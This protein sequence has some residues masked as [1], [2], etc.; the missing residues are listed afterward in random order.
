MAPKITCLVTLHGT[1]FMQPPQARADGVELVN[2]GYAD[3]LHQ[4]LKQCLE[5]KLSDDPGRT[6]PKPGD[7]GAIYV[8]S[9]WLD[10]QKRASREEELKRLGVWRYDKQHVDTP[11]AP[12]V[13]NDEPVSH[14][15]LVYSKL[16]PMGPAIGATLITFGTGLTSSSHYAGA[17]GLIHMALAEGL[18]M[19]EQ[20]AAPGQEPT[21]SRP[22]INLWSRLV[23]RP[24]QRGQAA[25]AA[26]PGLLS[27]LR[28]FED[29]VACYVSRNED[30]ER[31]RSFVYEALMR[32]AYREDVD[33]I[34]LN[35]HSNG[36]VI[37]FDVLRH[38]LEEVTSKIKAFVTAGSPL[39]KYV[40]CFQW[41]NQIQTRFP[42]EPWYN[43]WDR[44]DPV[45]DPLAPP[46]SWH[47][48]DQIVPSDEQLFSRIDL[49]T[50]TPYWIKVDDREVDNSKNSRGGG[51][52]VH[53]YWDNEV[54][55]VKQLCNIVRAIA[56]NQ[57]VIAE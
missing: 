3:P 56:N 33:T 8:E 43:F 12:L 34:V 41:G 25:P 57:G 38:L 55:F 14:V 28:D 21:S 49:N 35:T 23:K 53:N 32:L 29:D 11:D 40:D 30:R 54:E 17:S 44:R 27:M 26:S 13:A 7:N 47:L 42:V 19:I 1:G 4:H 24:G 5:E 39:R 36:T 18:A 51:L 52:Q 22:R 37:A 2:S 48:G 31:V 20:H 46:L 50:E 15:A 16:E 6:R 9:R 45:A 10:A